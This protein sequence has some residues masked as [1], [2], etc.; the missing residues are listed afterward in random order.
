MGSERWIILQWWKLI[1]K[2]SSGLH[3]QGVD[4]LLCSLARIKAIIHLSIIIFIII[5]TDRTLANEWFK[6]EAVIFACPCWSHGL[7]YRVRCPGLLSLIDSSFGAKQ[8]I[9]NACFAGA[10][11][12]PSQRLPRMPLQPC[13]V[14]ESAHGTPMKSKDVL[15]S[16]VVASQNYRITTW[17]GLEK[18]LMII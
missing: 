16:A 14:R 3:S 6:T 10:R 7:R 1:F 5:V 17:F 12:A 13:S 11:P 15:H 18:T 4:G 2:A 8:G 9:A